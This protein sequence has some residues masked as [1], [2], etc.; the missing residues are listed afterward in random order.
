MD[1]IGQIYSLRIPLYSSILWAALFIILLPVVVLFLQSTCWVHLSVLLLKSILGIASCATII[2]VL[3][4]CSCQSASPSCLLNRSSFCYKLLHFFWALDLLY[5]S[6]TSMNFKHYHFIDCIASLVV[7]WF[8]HF[9]PLNVIILEPY[10]LLMIPWSMNLQST[11][12]HAT[13]TQSHFHQKAI[14][15]VCAFKIASGNLIQL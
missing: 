5:G 2:S 13:F 12:V 6:P 15:P 1:P 14:S 3:V 8:W 7:S 9:L 10:R 4:L 11:L